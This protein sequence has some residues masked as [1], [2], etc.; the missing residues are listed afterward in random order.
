MFFKKKRYVVH[1]QIDDYC[2]SR[3]GFTSTTAHRRYLL[4]FVHATGI[5]DAKDITPDEILAYLYSL[6]TMPS[7]LELIQAKTAINLFMI[8]VR[9]NGIM[10]SS[11]DMTEKKKAVRRPRNKKL[12]EKI[13]KMRL[14][15]ELS[16]RAIAEKTGKGKSTI[17]YILKQVS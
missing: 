6:E 10:L 15:D 9:K 4:R 3:R 8:F 11:S 12:W 16:I 7:R 14:V 2:Y 17:E 1:D 13:I 5:K